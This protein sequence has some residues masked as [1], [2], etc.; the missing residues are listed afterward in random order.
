MCPESFCR[1]CPFIS[2]WLFPFYRN[3]LRSPLYRDYPT[4]KQSFYN[5]LASPFYSFYDRFPA[6][7]AESPLI[8]S[9]KFDCRL[10]VL[11]RTAY[12]CCRKIF[13]PD[14]VGECIFRSLLAWTD[15]QS[16]RQKNNQPFG[17]GLYQREKQKN[18]Q[19]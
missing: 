14:F 1:N 10:S 6:L 8:F 16:Y 15:R 13:L 4:R 7:H 5:I 9:A 2:S 18:N 17:T 3:T 19:S 12:A 11:S